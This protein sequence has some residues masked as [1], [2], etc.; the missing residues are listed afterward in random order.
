MKDSFLYVYK[1]YKV[2]NYLSIGYHGGL[3]YQK[4]INSK[5][6]FSLSSNLT[7]L[8]Q[9]VKS[10]NMINYAD[11][12]LIPIAIGVAAYAYNDLDINYSSWGAY[13]EGVRAPGCGITFGAEIESTNLSASPRTTFINPCNVIKEGNV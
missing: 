1:S 10:K 12:N 2:R 4:R 11:N 6:S 13:I 5:L 7:V 9:R 8:N 3:E